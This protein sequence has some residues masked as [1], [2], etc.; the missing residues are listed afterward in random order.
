[1]VELLITPPLASSRLCVK[2]ADSFLNVTIVNAPLG[3][4]S[5]TGGCRPRP[6]TRATPPLVQE[7][8][9]CSANPGF[10]RS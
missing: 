10:Y 5:R 7:I 6:L 1:M 9:N 4:N 8:A 2:C 3:K